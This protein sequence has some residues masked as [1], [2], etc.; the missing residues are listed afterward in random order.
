MDP[1]V[2][3]KGALPP[4]AAALL[5]VSL[6]GARLLPLA[7][8]IGLF[9]AFGL[10]KREWPALPHELWAAP[11]GTQWLLWGIA[12]AAVASSLEHLRLLTKRLATGV[13]VLVAAAAVWLLL[14]KLAQRWD[15]NTVLLHVGGGGFAVALTVLAC[16]RALANAPATIGSAV[17]FSTMLSLDAGLLTLA[18]SALL[19][20]LCGAVAAAVGAA[21]GTVVWRRGFAMTA[22]DGTWLGVAHGLFVLAGAH[23]AD[24]PWSAAGCAMAAPLPLLLLGGA[25]AHP[26][27]WTVLATVLTSLPL[28]AAGWLTY[29]AQAA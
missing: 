10:L 29:A 2:V 17:V 4:I 23:L 21:A 15:A 1:I 6:A 25:K 5:L 3:L 9:V 27:R 20:Q 8:A 12:A 7:M 19:G 28:A 22:A 16:R 13:G 26:A 14:L 11:N 18:T 24:L